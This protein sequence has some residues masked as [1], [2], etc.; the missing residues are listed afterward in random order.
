MAGSRGGVKRE[1]A[2]ADGKRCVW[3]CVLHFGVLPMLLV[4]QECPPH[5]PSCPVPTYVALMVT[6]SHSL[7][8]WTEGDL[9]I[10]AQAG[11]TTVAMLLAATND[12]LK[13]TGLRPARRDFLLRAT[14]GG[15]RASSV[16]SVAGAPVAV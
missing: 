2:T 6:H 1:Q 13:E 16:P 4:F 3:K 15:T 14:A 7:A 5:M 10:L 12:V 8:G 9:G 11:Y